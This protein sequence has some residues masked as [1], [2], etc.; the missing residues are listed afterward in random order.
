MGTFINRNDGAT[1][2]FDQND[3]TS[4]TVAPAE[5]NEISLMNDTKQWLTPE[6]PVFTQIQRTTTAE[7]RESLGVH[8]TDDAHDHIWN[9]MKQKNEE[10]SKLAANAAGAVTSAAADIPQVDIYKRK[11]E[12]EQSE[13]LSDMMSFRSRPNDVTKKKI[14]KRQSL[15][16]KFS[17]Q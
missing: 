11:S 15:V 2:E 8:S 6:N 9:K 1:D 10:N 12:V 7:P 17:K 13:N 3:G 4:A 5:L 16:S 14:V